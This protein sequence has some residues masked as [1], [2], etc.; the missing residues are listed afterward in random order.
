MDPVHDVSPWPAIR[1]GDLLGRRPAS[2]SGEIRPL[3]AGRR[4]LERCEPRPIGADVD[5]STVSQRNSHPEQEAEGRGNVLPLDR[6]HIPARGDERRHVVSSGFLPAVAFAD[7]L[8]VQIKDVGVIDDHA[9]RRL[10]RTVGGREV[11]RLPEPAGM[12]RIRAARM[13]DPL[14]HLR[15]GHRD[16]LGRER[17]LAL[18]RDGEERRRHPDLRAARDVDGLPTKGLGLELRIRL[19]D[20]A[21][22]LEA[23]PPVLVAIAEISLSRLRFSEGRAEGFEPLVA[24]PLRIRKVGGPDHRPAGVGVSRV[25]P[26]ADHDAGHLAHLG[27]IERLVPEPEDERGVDHVGVPEL[28][29]ERIEGDIDPPALIRRKRPNGSFAPAAGREQD[30]HAH[31]RG[32]KRP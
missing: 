11:E 21:V 5:R 25:E 10:F 26:L 15:G 27:R 29:P 31:D 14:P 17:L 32:Q 4:R 22:G 30:N 8:S 1:L 16:G 2:R 12:G 28:R 6:Q 13:P 7:L 9:D 20:A 24:Q 18:S 3:P 23:R 19:Q